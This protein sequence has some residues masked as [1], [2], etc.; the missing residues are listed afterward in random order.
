MSSNE[1]AHPDPE[2]VPQNPG[3]VQKGEIEPVK[4]S[5]TPGLAK[6]PADVK[7]TISKADEI[8]LRISK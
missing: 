1:A 7:T 3:D 6:L 8:I 2:V 5:Q 4:P